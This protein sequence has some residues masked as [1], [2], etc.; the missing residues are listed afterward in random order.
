MKTSYANDHVTHFRSELNS[1]CK[2]NG[3]P[4]CADHSD[5]TP[6]TCAWACLHMYSFFS[7][8]GVTWPCPGEAKCINRFQICDGK[9]DCSKGQD[10]DK[11][12]CT[13]EFCKNG[14]LSYDSNDLNISSSTI[15]NGNF[16]DTTDLSK[17]EL[18]SPYRDA[19]KC[20][21]SKLED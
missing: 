3:R 10:E 5:F 21:A 9:R 20:K 14:L 13:E 2:T 19:S 1:R 11:R 17:V 8:G 6:K 4:S 15:P 7:M 16:R 12:L 18:R